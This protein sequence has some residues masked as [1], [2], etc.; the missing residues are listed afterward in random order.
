MAQIIAWIA[1]ILI[2]IFIFKIGSFIWRVAG[3]L[4]IAFLL[5]VFKDDIANQ[6]NLLVGQA[7]ER[8]IDLFFDNAMSG[9]ENVVNQLT[10]W[11]REILA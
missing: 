7:G 2:L 8:T 9:F 1:I 6:V 4:V 5:Y 3:L 11:V 10:D